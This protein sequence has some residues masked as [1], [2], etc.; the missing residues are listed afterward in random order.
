[1]VDSILSEGLTD[2]GL[3]YA[4]GITAENVA[5]QF[6]ITRQEQDAF[7]LG[8]QMRAAKAIR[9]GH[10]DTEIVP[11]PLKTRKGPVEV[12]VDEHPRPDSSPEVLARLKPAFRPDGTVTAAN[13]SGLN[14][15]AAMLAVTTDAYAKAHALPILAHVLSYAV[16]G[17]APDVMGLGPVSA[18]PLALRKAGLTSSQIDLL[19]L[20]EAFAAQSIAVIRSLDLDPA[21]VNVD[22]GAIALGHPI[23][24]SG[25]R[26]LV[27]LVHA[28]RRLGKKHGVAS[29]CIGGGMGIAIVI[30]AA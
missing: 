8:S 9:E 28:L 7:A 17:I 2:P 19:E 13:A 20:N 1:L 16:A 22:G 18:V 23:G 14:D 24:A 25:A 27:T 4:M 15:G 6:G 21:K 5:E 12:A 11:V 29:L 26:V 3:N 10:F 30:A